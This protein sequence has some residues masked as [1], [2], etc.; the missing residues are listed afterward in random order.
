MQSSGWRGPHSEQSERG[1]S[2][3]DAANLYRWGAAGS[4]RG[5]GALPPD[6]AAERASAMVGNELVMEKNLKRLIYDL[7]LIIL[8]GV[9]SNSISCQ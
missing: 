1:V 6:T 7:F 5:A 3:M 4:G 2:R 9:A 8:K